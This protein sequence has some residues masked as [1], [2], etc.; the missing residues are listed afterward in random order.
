MF[1]RLAV[2][3]Q[4]QLNWHHRFLHEIYMLYIDLAFGSLPVIHG[5]ILSN[6]SLHMALGNHIHLAFFSLFY[7]DIICK[8]TDFHL[9]FSTPAQQ[10]YFNVRTHCK[11]SFHVRIG[12]LWFRRNMNSISD[13]SNHLPVGWFFMKLQWCPCLVTNSRYFFQ[14]FRNILRLHSLRISFSFPVKAP[15]LP[16]HNLIQPSCALLRDRI[17]EQQALPLNALWRN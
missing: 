7:N 10:C 3:Y 5:W 2:H 6:F 11:I 12:W 15:P 9:I 14:S 16:N 1:L 8:K 17:I 4:F 13:H